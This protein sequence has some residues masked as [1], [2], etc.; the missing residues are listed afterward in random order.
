MAL[1]VGEITTEKAREVEG[2]VVQGEVCG[3]G[4]VQ[5]GVLGSLDFEIVRTHA[6][7]PLC[8]VGRAPMG[9]K[10]GTLAFCVN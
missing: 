7:Y 5:K 10:G 8:L 4:L 9:Q 2:V 1:V 3:G 6:K